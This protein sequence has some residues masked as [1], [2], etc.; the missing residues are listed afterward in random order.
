M[1]IDTEAHVLRFA[2]SYHNNPQAKRY[3]MN[4]HYT[5]YEHP[6]ELLVTEMDVAGVDKVF[7]LSYDAE[8]TAWSAQQWGYTFEDFSGVRKHNLIQASK[9]PDRFLWFN[10]VK[11]PK[12]HDSAALIRADASIGMV[13]IKLFP[14]YI[15]ISLTEDAMKPVFDACQELGL[16]VL[17][18]F[19]T[20][21][22]PQTKSLPEYFVELDELLG[23]YP[24]VNF[25]LLH[26]G[27][28][29]PLTGAA[30]PIF[31]MIAKHSNLYLSTS[32]PG[33]VWEDGTEYPYA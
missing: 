18:S 6:S 30:D 31:E 2:R 19:E 1:I 21:R 26:N 8:D 32:M 29:D 33:E 7:L 16:R 23:R 15:K 5:W 10:T 22:P 4:R 12:I 24:E 9:Y 25:A 13:G 27:C 3:R 17:I 11:D 14:G 28:A 20:L